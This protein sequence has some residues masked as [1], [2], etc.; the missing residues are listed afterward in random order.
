MSVLE[1]CQ[2]LRHD[3]EEGISRHLGTKIPTVLVVEIP[4]CRAFG[5]L[6]IEVTVVTV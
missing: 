5:E 4:P 1:L 2:K 3:E 6:E